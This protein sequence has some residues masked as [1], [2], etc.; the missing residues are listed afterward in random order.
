MTPHST[1]HTPHSTLIVRL[2]VFKTPAA[3]FA[4]K[5]HGKP[6]SSAFQGAAYDGNIS[7]V[8]V[9][10]CRFPQQGERLYKKHPGFAVLQGQFPL[11]DTKA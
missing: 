11:A 7:A 3:R 4:G 10:P 1:L 2:A 9:K 6:A 8:A 5:I